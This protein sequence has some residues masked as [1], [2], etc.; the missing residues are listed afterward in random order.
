MVASTDLQA[1][2]IPYRLDYS[3]TDL[4]TF[5]TAFLTFFAAPLAAL[6]AFLTVDDR[7]RFAIKRSYSL[8]PDPA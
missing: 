6:L 3:P 4:R 1:V 2:L 8:S 7:A 5:R